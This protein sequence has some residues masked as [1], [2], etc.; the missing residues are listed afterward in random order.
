MTKKILKMGKMVAIAICLAG[1]MSGSM[2]EGVT[3]DRVTKV[4][5]LITVTYRN[6]SSE[7]V[8]LYRD[9]ESAGPGNKIAPGGSRTETA[10]LTGTSYDNLEPSFS[11]AVIAFRNGKVL[12]KSSYFVHPDRVN[13]ISYP[14]Q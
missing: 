7:E 6:N 14:W 3:E 5:A 1:I 10:Y 11:V 8:H 13:T 4:D 12:G 2:C 9:S